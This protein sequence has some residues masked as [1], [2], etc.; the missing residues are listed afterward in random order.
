MLGLT[1]TCTKQYLLAGLR[2]VQR[3]LSQNCIGYFWS[4]H[5]LTHL[6]EICAMCCEALTAGSSTQQANASRP[7]VDI[8]EIVTQSDQMCL[9]LNRKEY[10]VR[11]QRRVC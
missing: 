4:R 9:N 1:L 10:S 2:D 7:C 6:R 11:S 8:S 3:G 5:P